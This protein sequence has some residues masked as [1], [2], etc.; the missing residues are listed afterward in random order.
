MLRKLFRGV[1][2]LVAGALL[3]A[4]AGTTPTP[5][6]PVTVRFA[7]LP[8]LDALPMFVAQEKGYFA[9]EGIDLQVVPVASAAARDQLMQ[10]GQGDAMVN[11][12]ISTLFY[13]KDATTLK[14]VRYARTATSDFAQYFILAGPGTGITDAAGLKGVEIAI[15]EATTIQY[16]TDRLLAAEGLTPDEIKTVAIPNIVDR[17]TALANGTVPA[18][19]M[20]DPAAAGAIASGASIVVSDAAHPEL[21]HSELSFSAAFVAEH[22]E[23]VS[24]FLRA[25]EKAV[26]DINADKTAWKSVLTANKLLSDQLIDTYTLPDYPTAAVPTEAQFRDVNDWAKALGLIDKDLSYADSVDASFL[27]K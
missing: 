15:S 18:A 10:A 23:A 19:A 5:A 3:A 6:A 16:V 14:V 11:D 1:S 27:P 7:M 26:A 4:C 8:I 17:M 25:W 9:A 20:P 12:L 13:N 21:G 2:V 22:P 24:G